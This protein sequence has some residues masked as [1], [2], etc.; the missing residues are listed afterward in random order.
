MNASPIP[1]VLAVDDD[2]AMRG[3][4]ASYLSENQMRV[5]LAASGKAMNAILKAQVADLILLDLRMPGEDGLHILRRF[6]ESSTTPVIIVSGLLDDADCIMG[7]ELGADDYLTKPFNAR[8]LLARIR[9]VLR[10]ARLTQRHAHDAT[11]SGYR[12]DG[13]TLDTNSHFLRD[14]YGNRI[15][16]TNGEFN[17]LVAF[18][19][20]PNH[21]L[22]RSQLVHASHLHDDVFD[23]SV[24]IQILRLRRKI[25]SDPS[26]PRYIKTERGIGY[27]FDT[28][29]VKYFATSMGPPE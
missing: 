8:E 20:S 2:P 11:V 28:Q 23:R 5:T 17:L 29:V 10:R 16:L 12:F 1:H 21:I 7:L 13:W 14:P 24:D 4:V 19:A 27:R 18:L 15:E 3:L 25:E 9:S 6:R 22:S 26:H